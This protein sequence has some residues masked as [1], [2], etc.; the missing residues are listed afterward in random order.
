MFFFKASLAEVFLFYEDNF[1]LLVRI[2]QLLLAAN[3]TAQL[4]LAARR[5]SY[6]HVIAGQLTLEGHELNAGDV[7]MLDDVALLDLIAQGE[8]VSALVFDLPE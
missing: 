6:V 1:L 4:P 5:K 3:S 7:A 8:A 2:Y